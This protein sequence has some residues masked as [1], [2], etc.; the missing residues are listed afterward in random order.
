MEDA[1]SQNMV[2]ESSISENVW[3]D[4]EEAPLQFAEGETTAEDPGEVPEE[5]VSMGEGSVFI[6]WEDAGLEDHVMDWGDWVLQLHMRE[7]TGI[8]DRDIA[9]MRD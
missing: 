8:E 7:M 2:A 9:G 1:V 6:S 4:T 5:D 3:E